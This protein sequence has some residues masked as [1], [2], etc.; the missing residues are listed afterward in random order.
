[1][2]DFFPRVGKEVCF[3]IANTHLIN[4]PEIQTTVKV[5]SKGS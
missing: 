5:T 1:M 3:F 4:L 2:A